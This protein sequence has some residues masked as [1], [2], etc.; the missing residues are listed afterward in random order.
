MK[1][2]PKNAGK[3]PRTPLK[4]DRNRYPKGW[5]RQR[6]ESVIAHYEKQT[7]EQAAAE[8]EAAYRSTTSTM[9]QVPLA[10]VPKAEKL[11]A[12]AN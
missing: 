11:V 8:D 6:V 7:D 3:P 1:T 5:D 9:I 10:L 2:T 12:R 4:N